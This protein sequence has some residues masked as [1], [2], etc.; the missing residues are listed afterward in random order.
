M[1]LGNAYIFILLL[2]IIYFYLYLYMIFWKI[3]KLSI[4]SI[5]VDDVLLHV[6]ATTGPPQQHDIHTH[7]LFID[8]HVSL[9]PFDHEHDL[10]YI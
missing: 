8:T 10:L 2:F 7:K 6:L 5:Q 4:S 9:A 1:P 3:F